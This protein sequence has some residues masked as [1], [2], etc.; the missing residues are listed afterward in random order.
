MTFAEKI[1][2]SMV[3][4]N[5]NCGERGLSTK[6]FQ[7]LVKHLQEGETVDAGG[8]NGDFSFRQFTKTEYHG[9]IG[10]YKVSL[11]EYDHFH[12]AY[13]VINIHRWCDELPDTRFSSYQ[14]EVGERLKDLEVM[15][16]RRS[17]FTNT[18]GEVTIYTFAD[19]WGNEYVWFASR[20][21]KEKLERKVTRNNGLKTTVE[22]REVVEGSK[23][24][25]QGTVK[26]HKEFRNVKQTVLTR[27]KVSNV[28]GEYEEFMCSF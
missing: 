2:E 5:G 14:G 23:L 12:P 25:L 19:D 24:T 17:Y 11:Q 10:R 3:D 21:A 18:W 8:W 9:V 4:E 13:S 22:Y 15:C 27:C 7:A 26:E 28:Q 1:I 6:Q 20:R 16:T